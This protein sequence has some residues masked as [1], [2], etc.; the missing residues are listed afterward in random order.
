M[1]FLVT[2]L[3]PNGYI[4]DKQPLHT[5][6][7]EVITCSENDDYLA[8][9]YPLVQLIP[10][11]MVVCLKQDWKRLEYEPYVLTPSL[12]KAGPSA[13]FNLGPFHPSNPRTSHRDGARTVPVD[14]AACRACF[15]AVCWGSL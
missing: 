4:F 15:P 10:A 9:S 8:R 1:N 11:D 6:N 3:F 5:V 12:N 13:R 7:H 2:L 14:A